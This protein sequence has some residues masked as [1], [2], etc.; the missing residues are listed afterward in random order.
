MNLSEIIPVN[1]ETLRRMRTET[2]EKNRQEQIKNIVKR[3]YENILD[4]AKSTSETKKVYSTYDRLNYQ[5]S[6]NS[7]ECIV[8]PMTMIRGQTGSP[9]MIHYTSIEDVLLGLKT[10][11]PGCA[12]TFDSYIELPSGEKISYET[13]KNYDEAV[14]KTLTSTSKHKATL[15]ID[16]S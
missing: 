5:V 12:I 1:S 13:L 6:S 9:I 10:V 2:L 3:V 11:F 16:W 7:G 4:I 8:F 15:T 14:R